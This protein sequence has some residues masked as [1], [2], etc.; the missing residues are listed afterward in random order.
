MPQD[1]RL[2]VEMHSI[3]LGKSFDLDGFSMWLK[4]GMLLL[5]LFV[6]E[7]YIRIMIHTLLHVSVLVPVPMLMNVPVHMTNYIQ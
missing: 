4:I 6:Y 3:L 5:L 7:I 2:Y 1:M